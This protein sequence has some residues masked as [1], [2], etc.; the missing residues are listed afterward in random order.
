MLVRPLVGDDAKAPRKRISLDKRPKENNGLKFPHD[1]HLSKTNGVAQMGRR[2]S[3]KYG[4][5]DALECKDCHEPDKNNVGFVEVDMEKSCAMCHSLAFDK[6]GDTYRTLRH[7]QPEQVK[8]DR[9]AQAKARKE[10]AGGDEVQQW[11]HTASPGA[12]TM[13][14]GS[15]CV[16]ARRR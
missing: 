12:E 7:G 15:G 11:M 2:L 1:M 13:K 9:H 3:A 4:F 16:W 14:R 8:A 5:G 6:I 10:A